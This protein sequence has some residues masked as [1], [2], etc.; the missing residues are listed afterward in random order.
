MGKIWLTKVD[1]KLLLRNIM[2]I[3]LVLYINT[4]IKDVLA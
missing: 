3:R 4:K 1:E 2:K